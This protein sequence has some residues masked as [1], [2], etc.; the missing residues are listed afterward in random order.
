MK[1]NAI[2]TMRMVPAVNGMERNIA[3]GT[4]G[5][6]TRVCQRPKARKSAMARPRKNQVQPPPQPQD[7]PALMMPQMRENIAP[8]SSTMPRMSKERGALAARW[9]LRITRPKMSA[10]MPTGTL[11]KNTDCQETCSTSRPPTMGPPAVDAPMTMP[12]MPIAMFSF[13]AGKVARSRPSAAGISSAPKSPWS[14]RKRTTRPISLEK[15]IAAEETAKPAMPI[16][17]V[18]RWPKRSPS[19][20]AVIRATARASR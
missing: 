15:P 9:S 13:S 19:L 14:T 1:A 17:K 3:S 4:S 7:S 18:C 8:E 16:R 20:P 6:R 11:M 10:T 5:S 12:Q 2:S